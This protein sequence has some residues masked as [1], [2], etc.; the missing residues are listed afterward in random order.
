[1][2]RSMKALETGQPLQLSSSAIT[3]ADDRT[4]TS[5]AG[6]HKWLQTPGGL[7]IGS[8]KP[9]FTLVTPGGQAKGGSSPVF[10]ST[11]LQR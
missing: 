2:A 1:M 4:I 11:R 5:K 10:C 6:R 9:K 3:S 7:M 8:L